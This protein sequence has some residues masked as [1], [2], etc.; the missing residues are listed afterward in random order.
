MDWY[1]LFF[2]LDGRIGRRAFW[3]GFPAVLIA[4]VM[5]DV[6]LGR[7][8][9]GPIL[10]LGLLFP[11]SAVLIKRLHDRGR[12]GWWALALAIPLPLAV[13]FGFVA[14]VVGVGEEGIGRAA[15]AGFLVAVFVLIGLVMAELG[16]RRGDPGYTEHGPPPLA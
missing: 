2:S 4:L 13:V 11:L 7:T 15:I 16:L 9:L 12:T 6:L 5:V 14:R 8:F 3:I 10:W 1:G